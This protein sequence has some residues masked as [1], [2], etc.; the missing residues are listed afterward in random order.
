M[1]IVV[2]I[3]LAWATGV[4]GTACAHRPP[5]TFRAT[6]L[7]VHRSTGGFRPF[8]RAKVAG[9]LMTL[10][11]DTGAYRSIL[12]EGF[13]RAHKLPKGSSN[14]AEHMVDANGNVVLMP[15][16]PNV[17]VQFEGESS[18][19]TL[20]FLMNTSA[21]TA[22][23]ILAPQDLIRPGWALVIDLEREELRYE[24]EE[25]A[26]KRL[27]GEP[28]RLREVDFHRCRME[29]FFERAHRIVS[30]SINGVPA[31]MLVDTGAS[32]TVLA[33]NN[34]ALPSMLSVQG[35][36]HTTLAVTSRGPGL[37]VEDVPVVFSK[38]SFVLPVNVKP[39]SAPCGEGALGA[40]VL[41]HCTLVWG[42]SSLWAACHAPTEGE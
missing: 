34:P 31:E 25:G 12:P 24:P 22:E 11:L 18:A 9:E 2:L 28:T 20:D 21:E 17:P 26:L 16:L 6:R 15:L 40:D 29:G 3:A 42:W 14:R 38:T 32:R 39:V 19:G 10:L 13:A 23:G 37:V 1:R 4:L 41:R 36:R 7:V 35:N 27:S 30:T 5:P 8:V 33:R